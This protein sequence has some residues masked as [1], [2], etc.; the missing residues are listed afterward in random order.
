MPIGHLNAQKGKGDCIKAMVI[1]T[2]VFILGPLD[3]DAAEQYIR[4]NALQM[5]DVAL[6]P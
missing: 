4:L 5:V 1:R 3:V 6:F 2:F